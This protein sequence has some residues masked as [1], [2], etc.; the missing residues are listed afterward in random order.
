M[1][2]KLIALLCVSAMAISMLSGCGQKVEEQ[3]PQVETEEVSE[4]SEETASNEESELEYV[5]LDWYVDSDATDKDIIQAALDEYFLEKLNCKV[6]VHFIAK[7]EYG[8]MMSTKLMSGE[9]LDIVKIT[10]ETPYSTYAASGAL[11]PIDTLWD[12]YGTNVKGLFKEGVWDSLKVDGHVYTIPS[13]KDNAYIIGY[14]YNDTLASELGLDLENQDW[15]SFM[16]MEEVLMEALALRD[17]K[18]PEYKGMPLINNVNRD[19]PYFFAMERL[20]SGSGLA[21]CNIPG[22][23]VDSQYGADTV[24]NFYETDAFREMCLLKQRYVDAGVMAYDYTTFERSVAYEP[25]TLMNQAWG[26][27]W[28]S[29][30]L[31][32]EDFESKLVVF[33]GT[34]TES[35]NFVTAANSIGV[36][37]KDP[38][39]AMMV[40]DL[41]N[42]DPYVATLLRFGVEGEH[43]EYDENGKMQLCNRNADVSNPGW[44][45]WY[46][47]SYG[48][49]TI[50]EGPE[51]YTGPDGIMFEKMNEYNN[52]AILASHMGFVLDTTNITNEISACS[53]VVSEYQYL[54]NGQ[55]ESQDA[56]NATVDEFVAKL[57]A[58]GSE[59]IVAEIQAQI[60]AW[61]ANK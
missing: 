53:N 38:E 4:S 31:Y 11:Y 9:A 55:V 27:T 48:N 60:D 45:D 57:K 25:S 32:S 58:N 23:E 29:E 34:W 42:S 30:H 37:C 16:D 52:D 18:Y 6:N 1:K 61:V 15:T 17:E 10:A 3:N 54:M 24:F 36:N 56:V 33:D 47:A 12:E 13:L 50:V 49:I 46:G 26:Y 35:G 59:K 7:A 43:W 51:S 21:I 2:K 44:I 22:N 40:L 5:E 41:L 39:R 8:E 14:I 20:I 19:C 28:I